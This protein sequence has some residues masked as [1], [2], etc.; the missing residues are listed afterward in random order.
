MD[1]TP[2][3]SGGSVLAGLTAGSVLLWLGWVLIGVYVLA[4]ITW[5]VRRWRRAVAVVEAMPLDDS[6]S[7]TS[8]D[9]AVPTS[10]PQE[11]SR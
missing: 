4:L 5:G 7:V 1:F 10:R 3:S 2:A 8:A 6:P 9:G 11:P